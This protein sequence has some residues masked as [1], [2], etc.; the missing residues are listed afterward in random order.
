MAY[1]WMVAQRIVIWY[2]PIKGLNDEFHS[3]EFVDDNSKLHVKT[4][5][6]DDERG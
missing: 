2:S 3:N 5:P 6:Y 1:E 4:M